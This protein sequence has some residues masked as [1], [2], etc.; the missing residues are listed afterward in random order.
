[1]PGAVHVRDAGGEPCHHDAVARLSVLLPREDHPG[2]PTG[3]K[4]TSRISNVIMGA[5]EACASPS[6]RRPLGAPG[7]GGDPAAASATATLLRL[8]PTCNPK[9]RH[10]PVLELASPRNHSHEATGGV[11]KE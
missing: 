10:A 4:N 7:S 6:P 2:T 1:M 5:G 8:L 11:C 9:D 3:A